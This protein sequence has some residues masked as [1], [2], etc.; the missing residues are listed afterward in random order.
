[1]FQNWNKND[2][3]NLRILF[4]QKIDSC[5]TSG[6]G[7]IAA[8]TLAFKYFKSTGQFVQQPV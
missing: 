6:R 7:L 3:E 8:F 4:K 1:M 2:L 5:E